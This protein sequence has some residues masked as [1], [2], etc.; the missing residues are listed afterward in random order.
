[1]A[2]KLIYFYNKTNEMRW[3]LKFIFQIELY[4]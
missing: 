3:F 1:M 2:Y 4:V